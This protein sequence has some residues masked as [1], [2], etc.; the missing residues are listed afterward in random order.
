MTHH[1]PPEAH[2]TVIVFTGGDPTAAGGLAGLPD[3]AFVIAADSGLHHAL[4]FERRVDLAVGDFDS[5]DPDA[6]AAAE[7]AGVVVERHPSAKDRTDLELALDRAVSKRPSRI[8]VI[9][10]HGGRL[11]HLVANLMVLA[12]VSG[13]VRTVE[14]RL[15]PAR[16]FVVRDTAELT[17]TPGDLV[18]LLAV[19][20]PAEGVVTEGLLYP[21]R[22]ETLPAGST[23]GV[24]N[25]LT[26]S[27]AQVRVTAGVLLVIQPGERGSHF[28]RPG[29]ID[30]K[31]HLDRH[32][33]GEPDATSPSP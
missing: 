7:Q 12:S 25:E 3:D 11:D 8:V 6:L 22:S 9:G 17:G 5:V 31:Q 28:D 30:N 33:Q 10:G 32:H 15:G 29:H 16:A 4:A 26:A 14:A 1:F 13:R 23:R 20:G 19:H 2:E 27:T 21:L 24:S 18:T